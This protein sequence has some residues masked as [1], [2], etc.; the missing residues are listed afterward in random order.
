MLD[1]AVDDDIDDDDGIFA[2]SD[3][4]FAVV[5]VDTVGDIIAVVVIIVNG[6]ICCLNFII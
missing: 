2:V 1:C 3:I 5:V 6:E 4:V